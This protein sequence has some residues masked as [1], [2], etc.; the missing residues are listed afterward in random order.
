MSIITTANFPKALWPA[1]NAWY[2]ESYKAQPTQY[3][4]LFDTFNSRKAFEED[5]SV[6]GFGLVPVKGEGNSVSYDTMSQGF[7]SRY[8]HVTYAL[9]FMITKEM[10]EDDVYDVIAQKR[11]KAL[12]MSLMTT[13]ETVAA[14]IYNRAFNN[15]YT[16]GDGKELCATDHPN[17]AGGTWANELTTSADLSE[18]ALEQAFI[19]IMKWTN[20]RG[21]R[22]AVKPKA[23]I[24]PPDLVFEAERILNSV[25]RS[26]T[27][28]NDLNALKGKFPGGIVVNHYLS[29]SDAWFVR[30][31]APDGM[32]H[33]V[34]RADEFT[35]DSDFDT[36]NAKYK[37][38]ARFSFGWSDPRG[39]YGSPGA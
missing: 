36:D 8:S 10:V 35:M 12:A 38:S 30:T 6:S 32:K 25:G 7:V 23:L 13:K 29:D 18:A 37:V 14:N 15:S 19:D 20:D 2:G 9:G 24:I 27:A 39:I 1:V 34:R 21:L 4:A 22:I 26:G 5:V 31:D 11:A 3:T 33:F 16:G 28:D 17:V